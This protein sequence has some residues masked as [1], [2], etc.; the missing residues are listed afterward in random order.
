M[1]D[2][3]VLVLA[4]VVPIVTLGTLGFVLIM[5]NRSTTHFIRDENGRITSIVQT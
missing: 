4:L 1:D 5:A 2:W 3:V